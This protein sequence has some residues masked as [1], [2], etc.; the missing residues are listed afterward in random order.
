MSDG[1]KEA[2]DHLVGDVQILENMNVPSIY[3]KLKLHRGETYNE[4]GDRVADNIRKDEAI[5]MSR[6]TRVTGGEHE[7]VLVSMW[8]E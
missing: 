6:T 8:G 3:F 2:P 1:L 7:S 4:A 5:H